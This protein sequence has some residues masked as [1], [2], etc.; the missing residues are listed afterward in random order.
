[1]IPDVREENRYLELEKWI[2]FDMNGRENKQGCDMA[3][4]VTLMCLYDNEDISLTTR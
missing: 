3:V 2:V 1:M 4:P